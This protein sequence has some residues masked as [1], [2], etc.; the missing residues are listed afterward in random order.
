MNSPQVPGYQISSLIARGSSATVWAGR[1]ASGGGDL[2]IK[3]VPISHAEDEERL[4]FEL[5]ALAAGGPGSRRSEHLIEVLDVVG[6]CDPAP[7]VAIVMER[8]RHGTLARLVTT[9]GHLTPGEVVTVLTPVALAIAELHDAA[10]VHGDL[11][12]GNIGFDGRGRPVVLDLGVCTVIGTPR[13]HVYGTPGFIAPEVVAGG[14][15]TPAADVYAM[16][17][18]GWYALVGEPPAIPA[19]RPALADLVS[20]VPPAMAEALERAL[21][22]DPGSRGDGRELATAVYASAQATPIEPVAGEDPALMLTHRVRELAR[23]AEPVVSR[24][25]RHTELRTRSRA[26]HLRVLTMLVTAVLLGVTGI[27]VASAGRGSGPSPVAPAPAAK[28]VEP[29]A[30]AVAPPLDYREVLQELVDARARAWV[31]G[32]SGLL[33][34]TFAADSATLRSDES[35]IG[36]AVA[37]G[38]EYV[39]LTFSAADVSVLS[40]TEDTTQVSATLETSGYAVHTGSAIEQRAPVTSQVVLTLV[41]ASDGWRISEVEPAS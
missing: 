34:L 41:K 37:G 25:A 3:V 28:T 23:E 36:E 16:G 4:A 38:H 19:E 12:A 26:V 10:T 27:W 17:A 33:Q 7:G 24:R 18:L 14:A 9:R 2:A 15:P 1:P 21:H 11:S 35:L 6:V 39:G 40:E 22:P 5:A 20:S 13:E 31:N 29:S 30:V 8:L 32:D